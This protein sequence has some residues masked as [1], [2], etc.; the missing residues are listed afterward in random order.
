VELVEATA[1]LVG[2]YAGGMVGKKLC[3]LKARTLDVQR[4]QTA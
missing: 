1:T 2:L 4:W 3:A